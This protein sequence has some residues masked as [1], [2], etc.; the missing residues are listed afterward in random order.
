MIGICSTADPVLG[1]AREGGGVGRRGGEGGRER[2]SHV[3]EKTSNGVRSRGRHGACG[4]CGGWM[5]R[6]GA[7]QGREGGGHLFTATASGEV[8]HGG[9][10][11]G[12]HRLGEG[13][14]TMAT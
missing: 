7:W 12:G 3:R 13:P 6:G 9:V 11:C 4:V 10:T 1:W 8:V 14:V 2:G 5:R